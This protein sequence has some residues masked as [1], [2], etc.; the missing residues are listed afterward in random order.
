MQTPLTTESRQ[1]KT[2]ATARAWTYLVWLSFQR[3]A[4]AH[5]MVWIALG[6]LALT[7]FLVAINTQAGRW[8]MAH[9]THPQFRG[10]TYVQYLDALAMTGEL[11]LEPTA[12][13]VH[14]MAVASYQAALFEGSGFL[15]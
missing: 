3:Q 15:V 9:W 2:M 7:V 13:A 11:P 6:L 14:A 1:P 4:R 12:A 8:S 10:P 5:L